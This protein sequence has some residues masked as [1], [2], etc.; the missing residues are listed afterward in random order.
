MGISNNS[1]LKR[2]DI[3]LVNLDPVIGSEQGKIRPALIIQ[4]DISN[5]YS[6]TVI[7][8]PIT[9]KIYSKEYPTNVLILKEDSGLDKDSTI[10]LNQI[11]TIDKS[12]ILRKVG[13][14]NSI[15]M[16]KV[17]LAVKASLGLE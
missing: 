1:K 11:R 6:P 7:I 12:R 13:K 9:T 15:L 3:I 10:L 4:N 14:L 17:N 5:E 2:G 8:A 16:E